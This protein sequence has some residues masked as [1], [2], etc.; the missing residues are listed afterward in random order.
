MA[1][2]LRDQLILT[3]QRTFLYTQEQAEKLFIELMLCVKKKELVRRSMHA[4]YAT[5]A[6][7]TFHLGKCISCQQRSYFFSIA[8][9]CRSGCSFMFVFILSNLKFQFL[10]VY[11]YMLLTIIMHIWSHCTQ[12]K[13]ITSASPGRGLEVYGPYCKLVRAVLCLQRFQPVL[14]LISHL[15]KI[16]QELCHHSS[17][18]HLLPTASLPFFKCDGCFCSQHMQL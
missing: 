3:I 14:D 8:F 9:C 10:F 2:S 7:A 13:P 16:H 17:S 12:H 6:D 18:S 1:E 11:F 5:I 4:V 15:E